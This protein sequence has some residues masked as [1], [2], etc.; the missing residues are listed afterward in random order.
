MQN[1]IARKSL[2]NK[3]KCD[4]HWNK[5]QKKPENIPIKCYEKENGRLNNEVYILMP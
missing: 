1:K 5:K 3:S 2:F 4:W